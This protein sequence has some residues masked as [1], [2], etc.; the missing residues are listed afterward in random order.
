MAPE[1]NILPAAGAGNAPAG[2]RKSKAGVI[3][4]AFHGLLTGG[5][6]GAKLMR[7]KDE[8]DFDRRVLQAD[9]PVLVV[10]Y[11]G[12]C[13]TCL[14][15][16][17]ALGQLAGEYQGRVIFARFEIMKP[18]FV[19]TSREV[20]KRYHV[21][22]YP[23]VILFV[24]GQEKDRWVLGYNLAAY[25][26]ALDEVAGPPPQETPAADDGPAGKP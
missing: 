1:K 21:A 7:I 2:S 12:G 15:L 11:K 17:P 6:A 25:R 23:T 5:R 9:R 20:K 8:A 4:C 10:F 26:K 13:P 22:F 24:N 14:L 16:H 19:V 18:Y 3:S